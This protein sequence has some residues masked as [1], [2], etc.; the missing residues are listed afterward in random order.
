MILSKLTPPQLNDEKSKPSLDYNRQVLELIEQ[1]N[2]RH[3]SHPR[4]KKS[5]RRNKKSVSKDSSP[6]GS[7]IT[8]DTESIS[9]S[10]QTEDSWN[11]EKYLEYNDDSSSVSS[12]TMR[13]VDNL[14]KMLPNLQDGANRLY[15]YLK[16]TYDLIDCGIC[17]EAIYSI[18]KKSHERLRKEK[19]PID[20]VHFLTNGY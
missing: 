6:G 19:L 17:S 15:F 2:N 18:H 16:P 8:A 3:H 14:I 20:E 9:I 1:Y 12:M 10:S 5:Y 4:L 7:I 13:R 11:N